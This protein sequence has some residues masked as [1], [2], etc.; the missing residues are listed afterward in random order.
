V[1]NSS[2]T[3]VGFA[4]AIRDPKTKATR[5]IMQNKVSIAPGET[6]SITRQHFLEPDKKMQADDDGRITPNFTK[7]GLDSEKFWLPFAERADLFVTVAQVTFA[8]KSVWQIK[9]GGEIK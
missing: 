5:G 7:P 3:I 8:D 4:F 1:N 2:K 6:Y 9:E